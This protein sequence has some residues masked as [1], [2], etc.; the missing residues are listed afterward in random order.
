MTLLAIIIMIMLE[1]HIRTFHR[2]PS[3]ISSN[4]TAATKR[5]SGWQKVKE[6][7]ANDLRSLVSIYCSTTMTTMTTPSAWGKIL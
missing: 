1:E 4:S 7:E 6:Q 2:S 3:Y 5:G